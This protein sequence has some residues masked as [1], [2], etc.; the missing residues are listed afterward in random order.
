MAFGNKRTANE[1][2]ARDAA[3]MAANRGNELRLRLE[4]RM[5]PN[6]VA[7]GRFMGG[8]DVPFLYYAHSFSKAGDG[9]AG[10]R[11]LKDPRAGVT[12]CEACIA[13]TQ[14]ITDRNGKS[15]FENRVKKAAQRAAFPFLS[16]REVLLEPATSATGKAYFKQEVIHKDA[17]GNHIQKT[18]NQ[19]TGAATYTLYP[20]GKHPKYDILQRTIEGLVI[21]N[22]SYSDRASNGTQITQLDDRLSSLCACGRTAQSANAMFPIAEKAK[23][24]TEGW[25][26]PECGADVAYDVV[27]G[28]PVRCQACQHVTDKPDETLRCSAGCTSP[29]RLGLDLAWVTVTRIGEDLGTTYRFDPLEPYGALPEAYLPFVTEEVKAADGTVSRRDKSFDWNT[30]YARDRNGMLKAMAERG[31]PIPTQGGG[32]VPPPAGTPSGGPPQGPSGG[33]IPGVPSGTKI[34]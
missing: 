28:A 24:I 33:Y 32:V 27:S 1:N 22:G 4:M 34:W 13:Q 12:F 21:W 8:H 14:R 15:I 5:Y 29:R 25:T 3:E 17:Q 18:V 19:V 7:L 9:Y 30:I 2:A 6:E 26:C 16:L 31:I 11:C 23:V 10:Y 20:G